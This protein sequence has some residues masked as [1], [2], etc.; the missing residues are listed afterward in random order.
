MRA[1][2]LSTRRSNTAPV[3]RRA[4]FR[5]RALGALLPLAAVGG[6][7]AAALVGAAVPAGASRPSATDPPTVHVSITAQGFQP[8]GEEVPVGTTVVWTNRTSTVHDVS[9][10]DG[11]F[12]SGDIQAGFTFTFVFTRPGDYSFR[13]SHSGFQGAITVGRP[14]ATTTTTTTAAPPVTPPGGPPPGQMAFTGSGDAW[15]A[16]GGALL[17]MLGVAAVVVSG[18]APAPAF[19]PFR[20]LRFPRIRHRYLAD[21][22][23]WRLSS[24]ARRRPTRGW[25]ARAARGPRRHDRPPGD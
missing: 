21:L 8:Q 11:T 16:V 6:L 18:D 14:S 17:A 3:R 2:V 22:L 19:A 20:A 23:P 9:A 15:L 12:Y 7:A 4:P 10:T 1:K 24:R 5:R 13:D 25:S